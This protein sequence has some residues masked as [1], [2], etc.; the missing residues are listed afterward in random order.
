MI[1]PKVVNSLFGTMHGTGIG[2]IYQ[3]FVL[4]VFFLV[5]YW[6]V[7]DSGNKGRRESALDVLKKRLA[8]GDIDEKEYLRIKKQI[9]ED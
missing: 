3:L 2:W 8:S 1:H 5:V 6:I 9:Q 4:I 7:K